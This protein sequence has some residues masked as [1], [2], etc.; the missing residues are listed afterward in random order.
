MCEH[1]GRWVCGVN[2]ETPKTNNT[3]LP[4]IF[5]WPQ[6]NVIDSTIQSNFPNCKFSS[7]SEYPAIVVA[8]APMMMLQMLS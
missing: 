3:S 4:A 2:Y 6:A 8:V 7:C 5:H 1:E